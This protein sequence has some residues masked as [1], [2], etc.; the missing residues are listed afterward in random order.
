ME[1]KSQGVGKESVKKVK[2]SLDKQVEIV[3]IYMADKK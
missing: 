1:T 2:I 3:Y